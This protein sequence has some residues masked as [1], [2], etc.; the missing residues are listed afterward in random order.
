MQIILVSRHLKTA[1][2]LIIMPQH[3]LV[4]ALFF[5]G[6]VALTSVAFSWVSIEFRLPL[7]GELISHLQS[8]ENQKSQEV[9]GNNLRMMAT[10]V[11]ELQAQVLQLDSL[12]ERV[13]KLAGVSREN[14]QVPAKPQP[15]AAAS[16]NGQGGPFIPVP[17]TYG[18]LQK[19]I[20]RLS[21]LVEAKTDELTMLE[22]RLLEKKVRERLLPSMLPV[23]GARIGS[24]FGLR[25]DPINGARA[26]HEGLD[27]IAPSGTPIVAAAA[28][29]VLSAEYHPAFGNMVDIDHGDGLISRYAHMQQI[30]VKPGK[31]V[32]R[33]ERIGL[34]GSTGRSTGAHLHFEVR[35]LGVP[36]NPLVLLRQNENM[37]QAAAQ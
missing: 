36:Q 6:L 19:E 14:P 4:A 1:R 10:K 31:M 20:D 9:M 15:A 35:M 11:G 27:F 5:C 21:R 37:I 8:K 33:G 16:N 32:R 28:G 7:V 24:F 17:E 30:D 34:V 18:E 23:K 26:M 3:L 2:N 22:A 25:T 29:V 13:A 12:S